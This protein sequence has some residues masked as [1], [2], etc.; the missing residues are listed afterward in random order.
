MSQWLS[1]R[2]VVHLL[3]FHVRSQ[4]KLE[5]GFSFPRLHSSGHLLFAYSRIQFTKQGCSRH[6]QRLY[7]GRGDGDDI[8]VRMLI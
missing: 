5:E 6:Y 7:R 4:T 8:Q 3:T 2:P 1:F